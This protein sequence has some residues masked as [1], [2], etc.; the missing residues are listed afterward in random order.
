M[1]NRRKLLVVIELRLENAKEV[2]H[3]TIVIAISL[4]RHALPDALVFEHLLIGS[5]LILPALIRVQDQLTIVRDLPESIF[6]HC[7]DLVE[8][9][10]R[11]Q[12]IT[13]DLTIE[14]IHDRGKI[15]L[16]TQ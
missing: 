8:V 1:L 7:S 9:R 5:H 6:Q 3:D 12:R 4:S 14:E 16:F 11:G 15:E 13:D 2:F 10:A